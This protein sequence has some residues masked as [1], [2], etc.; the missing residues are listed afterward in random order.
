MPFPLSAFLFSEAISSLR[1][2]IFSSIKISCI[3][4]PSIETIS[5]SVPPIRSMLVHLHFG[6]RDSNAVI[7]NEFPQS[8]HLPVSGTSSISRAAP[9]SRVPLIVVSKQKRSTSGSTAVS[10]PTLILTLSRRVNSALSIS[11]STV[12]TM[13]LV[14]DISC[15][16]LFSLYLEPEFLEL[17]AYGLC[18]K[19]DGL[20]NLGS[21][22]KADLDILRDDAYNH[23]LRA[24]ALKFGYGQ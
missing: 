23:E 19:R 13:L 18:R 6:Q 9:S 4:Y 5:S 14:M 17:L 8:L 21:E 10:S 20:L 1:A 22:L 11:F 7:L 15:M 2:S 3:P 12:S 24:Q 16:L